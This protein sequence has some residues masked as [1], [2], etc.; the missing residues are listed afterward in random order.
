MLFYPC[1]VSES[2]TPSWFQIGGSNITP[3]AWL[4]ARSGSPSKH[5]FGLN[6]AG[7]SP[8]KLSLNQS[9]SAA[10]ERRSAVQKHTAVHPG[11]IH[12]M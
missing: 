2:G 5:L 6:R 7:Q 1:S 12:S 3:P 11:A 8:D 9:S 10:I 4:S